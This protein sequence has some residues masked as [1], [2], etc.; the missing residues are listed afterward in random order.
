MP[1]L[2]FERT[3]LSAIIT[4]GIIIVFL[5]VFYFTLSRIENRIISRI[6]TK[7]QLHNAKIF[8]KTTKY[9]LLL[10]SILGFALFYAG[11]WT[12]LGIGFGLLSAALGFA[13]QKPIT[14]IAAWLMVIINRPFTIGDRILIGDVRG[15]VADIRITHIYLYE[16]GGLVP[17]EENTNRVILIPNSML[18]DLNVI[19]YTKSSEYVLDEVGFIVT[20]KSDLEKAKNVALRGA[21]TI[22]G[23]IIERTQHEPYIRTFFTPTGIK[24]HI[25]YMS[26]ATRLHEMSSKMTEYIVR[27]VQ[28]EPNVELAYPHTKVLFEK[29]AL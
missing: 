28:E 4:I 14:G 15:D 6:K 10:L 11:S 25:R 5:I 23:D 29:G 3:T 9:T 22:T 17:G 24:I 7:R 19:N 21:H 8:F 2:L 27:H 12:G 18:F 1:E 26:P 20:F 13:L 16:V